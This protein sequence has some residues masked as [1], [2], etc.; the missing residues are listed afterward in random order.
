[1]PELLLPALGGDLFAAAAAP[2][3]GLGLGDLAATAAPIAAADVAGPALAAAAPAFDTA[4]LAADPLAAVTGGAGTLVDSASGLASGVSGIGATADSALAG[5]LPAASAADASSIG[6]GGTSAFAGGDLGA[7]GTSATDISSGLAGGAVPAAADVGAVAPETA[8][9]A[10]PDVAGG[11]F[12]GVAAAPDAAAAAGAPSA[13][14]GAITDPFAGGLPATTADPFAGTSFAGTSG[15]FGATGPADIAGGAGGGAVTPSAGQLFGGQF[16]DITTPGATIN[17][18]TFAS[19]AALTN[20]ATNVGFADTPFSTAPF[21]QP[22]LESA[23]LTPQSADIFGPGGTGVAPATTPDVANTLIQPP[24]NVVPQLGPNESF[25][26]TLTQAGNLETPTSLAQSNLNLFN[27]GSIAENAPPTLPGTSAT[28]PGGPVADINAPAANAGFGP[29]AAPTGG[30]DFVSDLPTP[31][32]TPVGPAGTTEAGSPGGLP[33]NNPPTNLQPPTTLQ[34]PGAGSSIASLFAKNPLLTASLG[35][36]AAGLGF[37]V[38]RNLQQLPEQE[39]L[40]AIAQQLASQSATAQQ[41]ASELIN[42]LLTGNL[43]PN[44]SQQVIQAQQDAITAINAKYA[45]MG[46]AGSSA[47]V[48]EIAQTVQNTAVISG[49]LEQQLAT[50]GIQLTSQATQSLNIE[51]TIFAS[52][53]QNILNSD[54]ALAQAIATFAGQSALAGAISGRPSSTTALAA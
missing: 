40:N 21:G 23:G 50:A 18:T 19:D 31:S 27:P 48:A 30:T 46:Q 9:A 16:G 39:Q 28:V 45:S 33:F 42:P 34:A 5:T 47:N 54:A 8:A 13:F 44:L 1:M 25:G 32:E 20:P 12:G 41:Q 17:P 43:P 52:L 49:Q 29:S 22:T 38:Y 53:Q 4:A 15:P 36:G 10:A 26:G 7:L 35:L 2:E 11:T 6:L 14:T 3:I 24:Q 37:A 51:S